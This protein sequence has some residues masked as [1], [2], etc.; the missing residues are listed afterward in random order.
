MMNKPFWLFAVVL[1]GT[2]QSQTNNLTGSPYSLF[3]LGV[4]TNS[5]IGINNSIGNGGYA[6]AGSGY[7]NNLN[8][9]SYG[10][11]GEQNFLFDFGFL[12][13]ISAIENRSASENRIAGSFSNIALA[14]SL[15]A[16]SAFGLSVSPYSDVGY[17]LIGVE[18]NIEGSF[19][20]F[21]SNVFGTGGLNDLRASY[22]RSIIDTFRSGIYE[23]YL[24]CLIE[25][26]DITD[27][28]LNFP[29]E[30][31][32]NVL[33]E[34]YYRGIRFGIGLQYDVS[35]KLTFGWG[36]DLT[37]SLSGRRDRTVEKNLDFV[38]STVE[39][40]VDEKIASFQLPTQLN[41][42]ILFRPVPGMGVSLDYV[43]ALWN[44]TEQ[45]DNVGDFVDEQQYSIGFQYVADPTSYKYSKRIKYRAGFN[46][47]TGYL[48]VNGNPINSYSITA[49]LGIPLGL[50]SLSHLNISYGFQRRGD[51]TGILVEES[52][53]TLNINFSLKDFWFIKRKID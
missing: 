38:P 6:I 3:G 21:T 49:G 13:E 30:S 44:E 39:N 36:V 19:E 11:M 43:L 51:I 52:I 10:K 42:G 15:S 29:G 7:I 40:E 20:S 34:N 35:P 9:A 23:S 18:S 37:T 24:F 22:G 45:R 8:P 53:H 1:C 4:A 25:E 32:L 2:I 5:N 46:Y 33:E 48:E 12:A 41:S 14:S 17:S 47:N 28:I 50:R 26:L 16:K 31:T 27:A